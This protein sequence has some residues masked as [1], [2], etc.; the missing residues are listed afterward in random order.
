MS[1]YAH[2][3]RLALMDVKKSHSGI[4]SFS[5]K[6]LAVRAFVRAELDLGDEYEKYEAEN[7]EKGTLDNRR[8]RSWP[9]F[10]I[11]KLP[12]AIRNSNPRATF[13]VARYHPES[14]SFVLGMNY[15]KGANYQVLFGWLNEIFREVD[16][17]H[18][19]FPGEVYEW[20]I[21]RLSQKKTG[22]PHRAIY[23]FKRSFRRKMKPLISI[24]SK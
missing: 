1:K 19:V 5:G 6:R 10:V 15:R 8:V 24:L 17:F 11:D 16:E 20:C 23:D 12:D 3:V 7:G 4:F 9:D 22:Q 13:E 21:Y 14:I 2:N 18:E